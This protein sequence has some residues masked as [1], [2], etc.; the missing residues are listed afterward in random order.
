MNTLTPFANLPYAM[1]VKGNTRRYRKVLHRLGINFPHKGEFHVVVDHSGKA[2]PPHELAG[3]IVGGVN[4][5][6]VWGKMPTPPKPVSEYAPIPSDSIFAD[7]PDFWEPPTVFKRIVREPKREGDKRRID[8]R[9]I[10]N[11]KPGQSCYVKIQLDNGKSKWVETTFG[12]NLAE[13]RVA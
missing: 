9:P 5:R 7:S 10:K 1:G 12:A 2:I 13:M 8:Y 11:P 3:A 4:Y 6:L